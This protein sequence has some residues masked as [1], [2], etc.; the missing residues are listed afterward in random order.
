MIQENIQEVNLLSQ[1][2]FFTQPSVESGGQVAW[3]GGQVARWP[4]QV[5]RWPGQWSQV[6]WLPVCTPHW[7]GGGQGALEDHPPE[8]YIF[9]SFLV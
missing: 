9:R 3:P 6:A 4:G 7:Q 8:K 2:E 1:V 5:F